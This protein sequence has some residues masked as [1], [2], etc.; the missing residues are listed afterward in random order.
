MIY[1]LS[2]HHSIFST[3]LAELRD[4]QIQKDSFRF[5]HN[6]KR[7]G[8]VLGYEVS[9]HLEY[10]NKTVETPLGNAI[11]AIPKQ[12]PVL[13]TI[14]RAGLAIHEG[15]LDV[16]D[17]AESTFVSAYSKHS[18][19]EKFEIEVEYMAGPSL[20]ER[21]VILS[22]PMLATGQSM[23]SVYEALLHNGTP[24]Q[25][26]VI[27]AISAPEALEYLNQKMPANTLYFVGAIDDEL[28]AQSYIVPGLG[29]AGDLAYGKKLNE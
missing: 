4:V 3:F 19:A 17:K 6:L 16:F 25:I 8:F 22:D 28:T 15:L 13:A 20:D 24:R 27:A 5:R 12:M 14:L 21:I 11:V 9:K 23:F 26:I 29:D 7:M 10:E 1:N 18:S 2:S